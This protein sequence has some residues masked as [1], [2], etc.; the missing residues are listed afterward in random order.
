MDIFKLLSGVLIIVIYFY[1]S[2]IRGCA[3]FEMSTSAGAIGLGDSSPSS[4][5]IIKNL[6]IIS[7]L[8][9][10]DKLNTNDEILYID[11]GYMLQCLVRYYYG[12][13]RANTIKKLNEICE[14]IELFLNS[15]SLKMGDIRNIL[16]PP[17]FCGNSKTTRAKKMKYRASKKVFPAEVVQHAKILLELLPGAIKGLENLIET[18]KVDETTRDEL[19]KIKMRFEAV[20]M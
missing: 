6:E 18:Y 3:S 16:E 8:Q 13:N 7:Q 20:L 2:K 12:C 5:A 11:T 1:S 10:Y 4:S 19:N 15:N 9:I 17:V 14:S